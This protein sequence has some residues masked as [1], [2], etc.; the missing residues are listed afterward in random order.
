MQFN[1]FKSLYWPRK[2]HHVCASAKRDRSPMGGY[3]CI[4]L[5]VDNLFSSNIEFLF[6]IVAS[7]SRRGFLQIAVGR[8][9]VLEKVFSFN[10]T[11]E[12][13]NLWLKFMHPDSIDVNTNIVEHLSRRKGV[14]LYLKSV[15]RL[16]SKTKTKFNSITA[17]QIASLA[18]IWFCQCKLSSG[19]KT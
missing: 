13:G 17:T 15:F 6:Y 11:F 2:C 18:A 4:S 10:L 3:D 12:P 5:L 14:L 16:K 7:S 1:G 19:V 8:Q 9:E